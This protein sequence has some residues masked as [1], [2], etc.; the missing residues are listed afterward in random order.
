MDIRE[1][2][3]F[4]VVCDLKSITKAAHSLYMSQQGLS[5]VIR[6][7]EK[8]LGTALLV[9][10]A[11][12][13]D[14]TRTGAYLYSNLPSFLREYE[15]ICSNINFIERSEN[16]EI[17]LLSAYG[18]IRLVT[19]ECLEAFGKKYPN[20]RLI[21]HEYPD[22]EAERRWEQGQ[23]NVAFLVGNNDVSFPGAVQ[24][25]R[26]PVR[27][28]VNRRHPLAKK[29]KV[30]FADLKGERFYLENTEFNIHRLITERCAAAGFEPDIVFGTS[31]FSLCHKMVQQNKGISVTVDFIFDDMTGS[32]LVMIPFGGE[33]LYWSTWMMTR[34]D[35]IP[36]EDVQLFG[37]HV[38]KWMEDI[39]TGVF[40]R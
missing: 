20:I 26:F 8:E 4:K 21:C 23:G 31:G 35:K 29:E 14:L 19:P 17:E 6:N 33:E 18:I 2:E 3:Y 37:G 40:A 38:M 15:D 9:R 1:L 10:K 28:L 5:K 36:N 39:R 22:R 24:M 32:D 11:S 13:I 30:S 27:L 12:G 34:T 25:E 7:L 16:H